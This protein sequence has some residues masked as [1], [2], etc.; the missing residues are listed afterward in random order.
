MILSL[1]GSLTSSVSAVAPSAALTLVK[2][3]IVLLAALAVTLAMRRAPAGAR[4]LVWLVALA[5][6]IV[7]PALAAWAP[8]TVR[9]LP[10]PVPG[11]AASDRAQMPTVTSEAQPE[12]RAPIRGPAPNAAST[13]SRVEPAGLAPI[14]VGPLLIALWLTGVAVLLLHLAFGAWSVRHIVRRARVLE[15]PDWEGPL[16]EVADRLGL[17]EAPQLLQSDRV[18]I[19]FA[20]G[21]LRARVVL[22]ADCEGW[23]AARRLAVLTHELGHVRRRDLIGHTMSRVA[24]ALYWFHPLV[25]SAARRLRNESERACD[26]LALLLGA[27]PSEYAEHLLDIVTQVRDHG[28]PAVALAMANPN[29]LEGRMLAILDPRIRRAGLGRMRTAGL[30]ASLAVLA[31]FLGAVSPAPRAAAK[32]LPSAPMISDADTRSLAA[33]AGVESDPA[34]TAKPSERIA[35]AEPKDP[36]APRAVSKSVADKTADAG[37]HA[38][39][40]DAQG[41][42][43]ISILAKT[44]RTDS[45]SEVRRVAAWGLEQ[46]AGTVVATDA[47]V[48]ALGSD[49]DEDVREMAA[50]ALSESQG[51][52]ATTALRASFRGDRSARVR[53]TAAWAAGSIGDKSLVEGLVGLLADADPDMREVAAWSIGSCSPERAPAALVRLLADPNRDVRLSTVW[54]LRE[55]SDPGTADELEAAFHREKDPEVQR[56]L[57]RALG[58]MGNLAVDTLTRLISS[59]DPEIRA[60]AV[61]AL[62]GGDATGSWP[63]PR[64]EPRPYP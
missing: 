58:S 50:W 41:A 53:K 57:I 40:E 18:R 43:R 30:V 21:L 17:R 52:A 49:D 63:W 28:T 15:S 22:P 7:L 59:P 2:L 35:A 42:Q 34:G 16:Y 62:A 23:S 26:D 1:I 48:S 51:Q 8:V 47:L 4:H 20:T 31:L 36:K 19:P 46:F 56:G 33:V 60:V 38:S 24:C 64:P 6:L 25:W 9:V 13:P 29:E 44:L 32:P 61:A 45:S 27:R 14:G 11:P 54:A 3:T 12:V 55:I 5:A 37:D 39:S 10:P